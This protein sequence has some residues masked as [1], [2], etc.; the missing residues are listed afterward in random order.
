MLAV[1]GYGNMLFRLSFNKS[2]HLV[3][4]VSFSGA[5][6]LDC[7]GNMESMVVSY[8]CGLLY[9]M[10]NEASEHHRKVMP[11][12]MKLVKCLR[13]RKSKNSAR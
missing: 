4:V 11:N 6:D 12:K 5:R 9:S 8:S 3:S 2:L 10:K 7:G 1:G 13:G